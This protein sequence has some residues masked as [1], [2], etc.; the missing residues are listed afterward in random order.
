MSVPVTDARD[1]YG[2]PLD[3]F[4]PERAALVKALRARGERERA[5]EVAKLRKPSV[6]A[7]AVNQLVRTQHD[8]I[9]ELFAAG[10]Q[11]LT[12][13]HDV[14]AGGRDAAGL[15]HA[16]EWVR[17]AVDALADTARGLLSSEGHE[18]SA[19]MLE[20]VR[21]TLN[22]AALER[23]ARA[24]VADGCLERELRHVGLGSPA[25]QQVQ[26]KRRTAKPSPSPQDAQRL[27]AARKAAEQA[28]RA[29]ER[30]ARELAGIQERRDRAAAQLEAAEVALA[31]AREKAEQAALAHQESERALTELSG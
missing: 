27:T 23:D 22:A 5:A 19:P 14:L 20:R 4:V 28:R 7:W 18:L 12:A 11:L 30:A 3:R 25:A 6:A 31:E 21:E 8:A 16:S 2:L 9:D 15:R 1:L 29:A 10:D 26:R 13:H 24:R 17:D